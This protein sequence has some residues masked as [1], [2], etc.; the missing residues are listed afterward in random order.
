M[1][2]I[3]SNHLS[4]RETDFGLR[5]STYPVDPYF[6]TI[7]IRSDALWRGI[8]TVLVYIFFLTNDLFLLAAVFNK[9]CVLS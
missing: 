5:K 1:R 7:F 4:L 9:L 6:I 8:D 2:G 3:Q